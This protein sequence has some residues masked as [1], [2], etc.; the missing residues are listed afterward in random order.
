MN[1]F[2][3]MITNVVTLVTVNGALIQISL[4]QDPL[5]TEEEDWV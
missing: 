2:G 5:I 1:I 3:T 4:L